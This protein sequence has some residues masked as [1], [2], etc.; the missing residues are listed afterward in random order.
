M[1]AISPFFRLSTL[2]T[3]HENWKRSTATWKIISHAIY[4]SA[5][6]QCLEN[7]FITL[8]LPAKLGVCVNFFWFSFRGYSSYIDIFECDDKTQGK[9]KKRKEKKKTIVVLQHSSQ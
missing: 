4:A 3:D 5:I 1:L 6:L 8:I 7:I 2:R 9:K